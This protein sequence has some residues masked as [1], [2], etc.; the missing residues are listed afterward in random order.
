LKL[1]TITLDFY[2]INLAEIKSSTPYN[3]W[4]Y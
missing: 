2:Q 1:K 3:I 4:K